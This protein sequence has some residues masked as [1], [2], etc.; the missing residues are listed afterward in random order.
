MAGPGWGWGWRGCWE[1]LQ[2]AWYFCWQCSAALL[3]AGVVLFHLQGHLAGMYQ[4]PGIVLGVGDLGASTH[5]L[6]PPTWGSYYGEGRD[7][8]P[9]L[10]S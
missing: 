2:G 8:K 5:G 7:L 9:H 3:A 6:F 4:V 1:L 10:K